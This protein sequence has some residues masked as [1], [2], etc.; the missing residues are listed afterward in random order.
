MARNERFP[1]PTSL[2]VSVVILLAWAA[3]GPAVASGPET[4][5][6]PGA[7]A[8][9]LKNNADVSAAGYEWTSA[10]KG[11][12]AARGNYLPKLSLE[13]RFVRTNVPA[14]AFALKL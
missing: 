5:D 3:G 11:A 4:V 7:V 13:E 6:F 14:E 12:E 8:R 1:V 9:A 2:L 10:R